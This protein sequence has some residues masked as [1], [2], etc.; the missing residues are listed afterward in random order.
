MVSLFQRGVP[1]LL[2]VYAASLLL[3]GGIQFKATD[4]LLRGDSSDS[5]Y[6]QPTLHNAFDT[7]YDSQDGFPFVIGGGALTTVT[8]K[9][10]SAIQI[11]Q[12]WQIYLNNVN[13]LLKLTHT[14][15]LQ[16]QIIEAGANPGEI[17]KALEALMF[18]IYFMAVTSLTED[19]VQSTFGED[20]S[21]MVRRFH[22]GTQ[23]SLLNAGFM[24]SSDLMVLQAYF[25]YLV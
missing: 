2:P 8:D 18:S 20:R 5:E 13:P 11:F 1:S 22:A 16:G 17:S 12:L 15:T 9:H 6:E 14:A 10:P 3:T 21:K 4:D 25:M 19:E 24:R 7:I 23:Q